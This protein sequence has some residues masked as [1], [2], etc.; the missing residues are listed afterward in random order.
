MVKINNMILTAMMMTSTAVF[1]TNILSVDKINN[2]RLDDIDQKN[3][4]AYAMSKT[5][6]YHQGDDCQTTTAIKLK[7]KD[8]EKII[9]RKTKNSQISI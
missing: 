1:A 9:K 3:L 6:R 8:L 2:S 4:P 7:K 5:K